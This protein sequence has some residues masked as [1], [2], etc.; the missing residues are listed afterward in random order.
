MRDK[1]MRWRKLAAKIRDGGNGMTPHPDLT[2]AQRTADGEVD[3]LANC[4]GCRFR[5]GRNAKRIPTR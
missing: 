3:S 4:V 1:A 5:S 2:D